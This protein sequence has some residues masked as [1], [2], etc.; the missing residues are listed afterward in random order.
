M[1]LSFSVLP[2]GGKDLAGERGA[3]PL[4]GSP[5]V[6]ERWGPAPSIECMGGDALAPRILLSLRRGTKCRAAPPHDI[7]DLVHA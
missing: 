7:A 5:L 1:F 3:V 4:R 6:K 2:V